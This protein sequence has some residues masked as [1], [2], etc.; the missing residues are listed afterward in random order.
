MTRLRQLSRAVG[1]TGAQAPAYRVELRTGRHRLL[2]DEPVA[3]GGADVGPSPFGLLLSGLAGCTAITLR[4]YAA[5]KGWDLVTIAVDVRYTI[6]ES[7]TALIKR[8]I[9]V[10]AS[11]PQDQRDRLAEIAER[12]PVTVAIRTPI[13]TTVQPE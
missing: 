3:A 11:L 5:R 2:A 8:K 4:M 10:P 13:T 1:S 12:T 7:G 6:A 9:T